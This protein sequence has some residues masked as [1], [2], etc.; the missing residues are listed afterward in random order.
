MVAVT[1]TSPMK[2]MGGKNDSS[3]LVMDKTCLWWVSHG[4][5]IQ[6]PLYQIQA[7]ALELNL[8]QRTSG[9]ICGKYFRACTEELVDSTT[10]FPA[11]LYFQDLIS[12]VVF[13]ECCSAFILRGSDLL[14]LCDPCN[15]RGGFLFSLFSQKNSRFG[16]K[17][18]WKE[19]I[20]HQLSQNRKWYC[21]PCYL[22]EQLR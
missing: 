7:A 14:S 18:Q 2:Q 6:V 11:G 1:L 13:K 21:S 20:S 12:S 4:P 16:K 15:R 8:I 22:S 17:K 3:L 19:L 5:F 9:I 10:K